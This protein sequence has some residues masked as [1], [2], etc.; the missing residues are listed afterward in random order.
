MMDPKASMRRRWILGGLFVLLVWFSWSVRSV[1]NPLLLAY[2]LAYVLTP[3]VAR[4]EKRGFG[5]R[6]AVGVIFTTFALS[7]LV[8]GFAVTIQAQSLWTDMSQPGGVLDQIDARLSEGIGQTY[9]Y[10][11]KWGLFDASAQPAGTRPGLRD[12]LAQLNQISSEELDLSG[13]GKAGMKAAGGALIFVRGFFGSL[14]SLVTLLFLLPIYTYFMM[15]EL[16]RIHA[17]VIKYVP[18]RNRDMVLSIARQIGLVL[19]SFLRGRMLISLLKGAFITLGLWLIGVPYALLL[20]LVAALLSLIPVVGPLVAFVLG[21][22]LAMLKFDLFEALWR[23]GLI[24][25]IAEILE[26]YVLTPKI[27]GESLGLHPVVVLASLTIGGA[28]LG[29]F[30]IL[31]ALPIAA[32]VIILTRELVLPAL[33][34]TTQELR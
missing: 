28:A 32:T 20:G 12:L 33:S 3:L 7:I 19:S 13:A 22:V 8:V 6:S 11:G 18:N 30:G 26:G 14:F 15:F 25:L 4:L 5:R 21:A 23:T 10:L 29:M 31:L 24:Y 17:F 2:L 1:L 34:K 27:L 9:Q 16:E